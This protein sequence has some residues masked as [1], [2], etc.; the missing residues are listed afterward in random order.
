MNEKK[1]PVREY[2]EKFTREDKKL[3]YYEELHVM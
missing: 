3:T 2:F 1:L